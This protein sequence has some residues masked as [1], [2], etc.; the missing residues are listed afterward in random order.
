[1]IGLTSPLIYLV[2]C[3]VVNRLV[4]AKRA[5]AGFWPLPEQ[6]YSRLFGVLAVV[7]LLTIPIVYS[8]KTKWALKASAQSDEEVTLLDST[9]GRRFVAVFM[10]C[11]TVALAGLILFLVQGRLNAM[12]FFGILALFNYAAAH[13]GPREIG[14]G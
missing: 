14:G 7:A 8:L 13:P 2:I 6:T 9:R 3:L 11:D 10:I 1:M 5:V 4:F 12:L